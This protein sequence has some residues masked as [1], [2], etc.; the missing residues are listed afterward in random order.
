MTDT[1]QADLDNHANQL[2]PNNDEYANYRNSGDDAP[3]DGEFEWM[4]DNGD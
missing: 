4:P 2:N 1:T 3:C